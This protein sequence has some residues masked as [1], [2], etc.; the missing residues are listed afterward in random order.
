MSLPLLFAAG[1]RVQLVEAVP[2]PPT[3]RV[4]RDYFSFGVQHNASL[5]VESSADRFGYASLH[6]P[7]DRR[8]GFAVSIEPP[9][10]WKGL[11]YAT[12]RDILPLTRIASAFLLDPPTVS[13]RR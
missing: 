3:L 12:R 5:R 11:I 1:V 13:S 2:T 4:V 10:T 7:K 6:N 9:G 8:L